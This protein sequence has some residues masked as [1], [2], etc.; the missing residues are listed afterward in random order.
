MPFLTIYQETCDNTMETTLREKERAIKL[1]SNRLA[2]V[3]RDQRMIMN[4]IQD[5]GIEL[6]KRLKGG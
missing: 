6:K 1:L 5:G 2:D 4:L 3:E